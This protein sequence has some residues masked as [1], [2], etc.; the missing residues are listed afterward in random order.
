ME[1]EIGRKLRPVC[2]LEGAEPY[3]DEAE[4][5]AREIAEEVREKLH[6]D[7]VTIE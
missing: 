6:I 1:E 5:K 2:R 4:E 7:N 3:E